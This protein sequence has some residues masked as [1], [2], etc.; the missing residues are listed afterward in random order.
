MKRLL[1]ILLAIAAGA[2]TEAVAQG[3]DLKTKTNAAYVSTFLQTDSAGMTSKEWKVAT[4]ELGPGSI[5]S[6]SVRP[7]T[8]LVYVL[9]G[10]G[11]LEL[12]GKATLALRPGIAAA[13][14]P[15]KPH[16]LKNTSETETLRVLV[17]LQRDKDQ[18]GPTVETA[19]AKTQH[20]QG[21]Q[22]RSRF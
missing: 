20:K 2:F 13:L 22:E 12:D 6:R 10:G 1:S 9:E 8:G 18:H 17:V 21:R 19:G 15:E 14:N 4:V 7:G 11:I 16:V 5:D 3:Q